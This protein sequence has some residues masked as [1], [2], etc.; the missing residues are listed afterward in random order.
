M[1]NYVNIYTEAVPNPNS[2]KF[3][4]NS[5]LADP[6]AQGRDY[7]SAEETTDSPLAE[8]LFKFDFTKRVFISKNFVTVTKPEGMDWDE[9]LPVVKNFLK[10]Y[11][12]EGSP[13]FA[14]GATKQTDINENDSEVIKKIKGILDEYVRPAVEGDGGAITFHSFD[15][16]KGIVQVNLQGSCSGCP[17]STITLKAGIENLLKRMLP[18]QI[19]EVIA[20]GV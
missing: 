18:N 3:V 2:M 17:S 9:I 12:E 19:N 8:E 5:M 15:E 11:F 10:N 1:N 7:A 4:L 14:E 13:V 6:E 20:Q 16:E